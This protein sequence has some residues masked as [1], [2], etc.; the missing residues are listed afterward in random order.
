VLDTASVSYGK[1][2]TYFSAEAV[3]EA[4]IT[5]LDTLARQGIAEPERGQLAHGV[6]N[7]RDA[8]F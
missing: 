8:D 3:E 5:V 4:A 6:R 2:T 7:Q 1:A